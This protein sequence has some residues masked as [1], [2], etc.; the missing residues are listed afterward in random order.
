MSLESSIAGLTTQAGLLLDLP[1]AIAT[2][3]NAKIA[4]LGNT[5]NATLASLSRS[6]WLNTVTGADTN[7]GT[8][9]AS[10]YKTLQKCIDMTPRGGVC[11]V[12]LDSDLPISGGRIVIEDRRVSL[13]SAGGVIRNIT[14]DRILKTTVTPNQRELAGFDLRGTSGIEL[15]QCRINM[16]ALDG[17]WPSY[18][19]HGGEVFFGGPAET[20][21]K[22]SVAFINCEIANQSTCFGALFNEWIDATLIVWTLTVTGPALLGRVH[23]NVTSTTGT[24]PAT[25]S[26]FAT[27]LTQI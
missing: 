4:E 10:A 24:S 7:S 12:T 5:F 14:P 26:Q 9:Q 11:Y 3:A 19:A 18:V 21:G 16:P 27:N 2:A 1:Q 25:L 13:V 22:K 15:S 8:T 20:P 6:F 23:R 17:V